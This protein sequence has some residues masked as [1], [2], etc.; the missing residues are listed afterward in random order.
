MTVNY[1]AYLNEKMHSAGLWLMSNAVNLSA[2]SLLR[3]KVKLFALDLEEELLRKSQYF[4]AEVFKERRLPRLINLLKHS[5]CESK[6]YK[7]LFNSYGVSPND[8]KNE[9]DLYKFPVLN[10]SIFMKNKP[11]YF[12]TSSIYS[13]RTWENTTSGSTGE[14]FRYF[15]DFK[16]NATQRANFYRPWRCS[17]IDPS[18]PTVHCSAP[19]ASDFTPNTISLHPHYIERDKKDYIE[20]IKKSGAKIIRGYPLT[21]F[22]LCQMLKREGCSDIKFSHAFLVGHV[23]SKGVRDFFKQEF[24][25]EVYMYYASMELGSIGAECEFH[26]GLHVNEENLIVEILDKNNNKIPDGKIGRIV[27]TSLLNEI[28]PFIRYDTGDLGLI[29]LGVCP[30]GRTLKRVLVEGRREDLLIGANHQIIYP[31]IIRDILDE[32]FYAF[33]RYQVIQTL[34]NTITLNVVP[35]YGFASEILDEAVKNVSNCVGP[36]MK[37]QGYK[38][39][40]IKILP[41]GKFKYFISEYWEK[42]FPQGFFD[43]DISS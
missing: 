1:G 26:N 12:L 32:Y 31:G 34:E 8:L 24:D 9:S 19:H 27:V 16:F 39:D 33:E 20:K 43:Y 38:V 28:M 7:D 21:N 41:N 5:Y 13:P 6:L 23:I 10:K 3:K 36:T 11:S 15:G 25:C 42:R 40:S 22:E 29:M 2:N 17:G 18:E 37:V 30:C 14:P 35:A 4:S